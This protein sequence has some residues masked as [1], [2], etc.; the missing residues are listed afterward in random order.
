MRHLKLSTLSAAVLAASAMN[1]QA[2]FLNDSHFDIKLRNAH[3]EP[4]SG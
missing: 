2:D 1:A 3:F 4:Q